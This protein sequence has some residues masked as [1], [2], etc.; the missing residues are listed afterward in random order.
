LSGT[1]VIPPGD[2]DVFAA[3]TTCSRRSRRVRAVVVTDAA[4]DRGR[5][6]GVARFEATPS[7]YFRS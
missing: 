6:P 2:H 5:Y 7:G 1:F 4:P 3:I